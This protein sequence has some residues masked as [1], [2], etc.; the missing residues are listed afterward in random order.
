MNRSR[1]VRVADWIVDNHVLAAGLEAVSMYL[2]FVYLFGASPL[3]AAACGVFGGAPLAWWL[4]ARLV[5]WRDAGSFWREGGTDK[6][7]F[8]LFEKMIIERFTNP[9]EILMIR[10]RIAWTPWGGLYVHRLMRSD[11]PVLHDHPWTSL[12]LQ[13]GFVRHA[14]T[15]IYRWLSGRPSPRVGYQEIRG[16]RGAAGTVGRYPRWRGPWSLTLRR[17]TDLHYISIIG[18]RDVYTVFVV[19]PK[20][21]DWGFVEDNGTWTYWKDHPLGNKIRSS[22]N[23]NNMKVWT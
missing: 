12:S 11:E 5:Q 2:L 21:K 14:I 10:Y 6:R 7:K 1:V 18:D 16:K 9:D 17:A 4:S 15:T 22:N 19:G 20:V 23:N 13:L 3:V 8:G